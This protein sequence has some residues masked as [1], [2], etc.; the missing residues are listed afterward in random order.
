ML[1]VPL[2]PTFALRHSPSAA[3]AAIISGLEIPNESG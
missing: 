2:T 1:T 3:Q